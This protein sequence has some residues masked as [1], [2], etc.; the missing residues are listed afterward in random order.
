MVAYQP[1]TDAI[2]I[3]L[4]VPAETA[5]AG[6][7][8]SAAVDE[9]TAGVATGAT[10]TVEFVAVVPPGEPAPTSSVPSVADAA[11]TN[12]IVTAV[13]DAAGTNLVVAAVPDEAGRL[14]HRGSKVLIRL[15]GIPEA[16]EFTDQIDDAG[17]VTFTHI[18]S[19]KI[20]GL[21]TA[22]AERLVEQM[23]VDRQVYR[24]INVIITAEEEDYFVLGEV[25]KPGKYSFT[26]KM[27]LMQAVSEAG[28]FTPFAQRRKIKVMKER[29]KEFT[30]Y[31]AGAIAD[32]KDVDPLIEPG[33]V[34]DVPRRWY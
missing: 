18:G 25:R 26:R 33:D 3:A 17:E 31:D 32:G 34:I 15:R 27:T 23:Y 21:S 10:S 30:L 6:V 19:V 2:R 20:A 22:D 29:T 8:P 14:L 1:M 11:G 24:Q 28:G 7:V 13:P 5:P 4:P 12:L 16:E 9:S